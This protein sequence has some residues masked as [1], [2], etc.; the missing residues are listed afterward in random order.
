MDTTALI[1]APNVDG[2]GDGDREGAAYVLTGS[3]ADWSTVTRITVADGDGGDRLGDAVALSS[4]GATALL[5]APHANV[6]GGSSQGAAYVFRPP[7][8]ATTLAVDFAP[9]SSDGNGVFEP[10]EQVA[11]APGGDRQLPGLARRL[12]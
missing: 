9:S 11:L 8:L 10:D 5:G 4:S 1:G 3:G 6:N 12:L 2:D 7:L